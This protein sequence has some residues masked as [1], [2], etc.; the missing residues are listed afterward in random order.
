MKKQSQVARVAELMQAQP[1]MSVEAMAEQLGI[2]KARLYVLRSQ[3]KK[4]G[5]NLLVVTNGGS[6]TDTSVTTYQD[7]NGHAPNPHVG[8]LKNIDAVKTK[9]VKAK[10]A[11]DV[12]VWQRYHKELSEKYAQV[13]NELAS[14]R[15]LLS[16]VQDEL[17]QAKIM[18][19]N[20][21]AVV[22]YLE[23]KLA[24]AF[25]RKYPYKED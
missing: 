4:K 7:I 19:L 14:A 6:K 24:K 8:L 1:Q 2:P 17:E 9:K 23:L 12:R 3:V 20:S 25:T 10:P 16:R 15:A 13:C 21:E 18:Y 5:W 11:D 22:E